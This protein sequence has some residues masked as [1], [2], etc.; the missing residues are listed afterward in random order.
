M[1]CDC[2]K[3]SNHNP[4][5]MQVL[6]FTNLVPYCS[7]LKEAPAFQENEGSLKDGC[8]GNK[9]R[10][11]QIVGAA[12]LL[13]TGTF[14]GVQLIR[15]K[16]YYVCTTF[17]LIHLGLKWCKSFYLLWCTHNGYL[18]IFNHEIMLVKQPL[19]SKAL[20]LLWQILYPTIEN[21]KLFY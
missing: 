16:K 3:W 17:F 8:N 12:K 7:C 1:S 5:T 21:G 11:K 14:C 19:K 6:W 4:C 18:S 10:G 20:N 2:S 15:I 9:A 13:A